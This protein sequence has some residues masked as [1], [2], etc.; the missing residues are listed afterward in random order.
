M[1]SY[2]IIMT[3][4]SE[5]DLIELSDYISDVLL[6]PKTAISYL[7]EI[8]N[9]IKKLE[10][11]PKKYAILQEEPFYSLKI[12][13]FIVNNFF[14]YYRIDEE[15]RIVYILNIIYYKREQLKAIIL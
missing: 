8:R 11:F 14:V 10:N 15:N 7:R 12:R 9:E 6:A 13:R 5:N 4:D 3:P 1:I 2:E